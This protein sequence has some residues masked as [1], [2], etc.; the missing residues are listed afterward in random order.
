MLFNPVADTFFLSSKMFTHSNVHSYDE[1]ILKVVRVNSLTEYWFKW[2]KV[3]GEGWGVR[4]EGWSQ[5]P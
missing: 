1:V 5:D 2:F 3:E 4:D